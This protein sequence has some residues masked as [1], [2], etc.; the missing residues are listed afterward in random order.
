MAVDVETAAQRQAKAF[1]ERALERLALHLGKLR[2]AGIEPVIIGGWA[3]TAHG[4]PLGS[5][6]IDALIRMKDQRAAGDALGNA[7]FVAR[8]L[9]GDSLFDYDFYDAKNASRVGL[10]YQFHYRDVLDGFVVRKV[11]PYKGGKVSLR[12]PDPTALFFLKAKAFADRASCYHW[13]THPDELKH[14]DD[15]IKKFIGSEA[16]EYWA[17]KAAKDM[18]DLAFLA[19]LQIDEARLAK[20]FEASGLRRFAIREWTRPVSDLQEVAN[21]IRKEAGL[22][23][24]FVRSRFD[25]V[26]ELLS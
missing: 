24:G 16:K 15:E 13:R 4:S 9:E 6:D 7:D 14:F 22:A 10:P 23:E 12:V 21:R 19:D 25:R 11:L 20:L 3:V 18:D 5:R 8:H 1:A 2:A 26:L 17:A